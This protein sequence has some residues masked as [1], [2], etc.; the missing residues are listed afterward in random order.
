[1]LLKITPIGIKDQARF[2]H[3]QTYT[4]YSGI[5][6]FSWCSGWQGNAIELTLVGTEYKREYASAD[7]VD[8]QNLEL[9]S[10]RDLEGYHVLASFVATWEY[11]TADQ[12]A[13]LCYYD[14]DIANGRGIYSYGYRLTDR[15]VRN[16]TKWTVRQCEDRPRQIKAARIDEQ[17]YRVS[18][19]DLKSALKGCKQAVRIGSVTVKPAILKELVQSISSEFVEL[20]DLDGK[21]GVRSME[22]RKCADDIY[23]SRVRCTLKHG[24]GDPYA[25]RNGFEA[26]IVLAQA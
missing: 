15:K 9:P 25:G 19:K 8:W 21:L 23:R 18:V 12:R 20:A 10:I 26:R 1:M 5:V 13:D 14:G 4:G 17:W 16:R 7:Q 24:A 2:Y 3:V 11:A 6:A 22:Q